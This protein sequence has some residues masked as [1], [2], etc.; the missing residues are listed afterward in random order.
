MARKKDNLG[1]KESHIV[2]I[3]WIKFTCNK[4]HC[5]VLQQQNALEKK[6]KEK[7]PDRQ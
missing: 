3:I 2:E 5:N 6:E 7:G 1:T 4:E